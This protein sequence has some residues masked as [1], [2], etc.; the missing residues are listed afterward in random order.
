MAQFQWCAACADPADRCLV[1]CGANVEQQVLAV[2]Q[3]HELAAIVLVCGRGGF[4]GRL[5]LRQQRVAIELDALLCGERCNLRLPDFEEDGRG[6]RVEFGL[7]DIG[8]G[9]GLLCFAVV[10]R[11]VQPREIIVSS[12]MYALRMWSRWASA[13]IRRRR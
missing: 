2:D 6:A 7:R 10:A 13:C 12:A 1:V 5:G 3:V 4:E 11:A 9:I 8:C